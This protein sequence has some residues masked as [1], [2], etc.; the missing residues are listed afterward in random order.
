MRK[1]MLVVVAALS[2]LTT[3]ANAA[4]IFAEVKTPFGSSFTQKW[5]KSRN[6][7]ARERALDIVDTPT[8]MNDLFQCDNDDCAFDAMKEHG[9]HVVAIQ[10]APIPDPPK[11]ITNSSN[12]LYNEVRYSA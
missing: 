4:K 3:N 7:F 9:Y 2:M 10:E 6:D 11:N 1:M 5:E 8:M 12:K